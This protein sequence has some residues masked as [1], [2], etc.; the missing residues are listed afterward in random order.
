MSEDDVLTVESAD[1]TIHI[2][3]VVTDE[4]YIKDLA[5]F[6]PGLGA[7]PFES[8]ALVDSIG[9]E[10]SLGARAWEITAEVPFNFNIEA[11]VVEAT[12]LSGR[13]G[14]FELS[15]AKSVNF[16]IAEGDSLREGQWVRDSGDMDI[17][18]LV[19]HSAILP[20]Q[21]SL[22][23]DGEV[24]GDI[25]ESSDDPLIH[26]ISH[27]YEWAP[28]EHKIE[29]LLDGQ[30][31]YGEIT[32][33]V[34]S[35]VRLLEGIIFPNPFRNQA[36]FAYSLTGQAVEGHLK[37]YTISGRLIR[38]L[39]LDQLSEGSEHWIEWDGLDESGDKVANGT[40]LS[41]MVIK[42]F[43]GDELIWQDRVVRMR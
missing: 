12:D 13:T 3:A 30:F 43:E 2:R 33:V 9:A 23:V 19:P 37:I 14:R 31:L 17:S 35:E 32:L 21:F 18:I 8:R 1:D 4:A 7:L 20:S 16:S 11:L 15:N 40:Y 24:T 28:G 6:D 39:E 5:L 38:T 27:S 29:V 25:G 26:Q 42:D 10:N 34:D 22:R 41:R 36:L